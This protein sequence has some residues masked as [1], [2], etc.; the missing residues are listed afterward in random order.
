MLCGKHCMHARTKPVIGTAGSSQDGHARSSYDRAGAENNNGSVE[1][2][3]DNGLWGAV[4][5]IAGYVTRPVSNYM[6]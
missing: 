2:Q 3:E 6:H 1:D 5:N 4:K